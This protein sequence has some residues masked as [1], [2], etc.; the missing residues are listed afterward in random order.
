M[1]LCRFQLR[2]LAAKDARVPSSAED[3]ARPRAG[4]VEGEV[5]FEIR[6]DLWDGRERTGRRWP[7]DQVK[8]L[9][10]V[11]PSKI[12]CIGRNYHEHIKEFSNPVPKQ[13]LLFLKPPSS[14]IASEEAIVIPRISDYVG[15]EGELA[16]IIGRRCFHLRPDDDV[17]PYILGYTPLND[18][19]ARDLQKIDT[20]WGRAKGFDTFCPL[21]PVLETEHPSAD[22]RVETVVNGVKKQSERIAEMIFSIDVIINWISQVMTLEPGDVIA[23]GTPAGVGQ[24]VAGDTVE[25]SVS[26]IGTLRNTVVD[27]PGGSSGA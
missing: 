23:T 12:L 27:P 11:S 16:V 1:K 3:P 7:G 8:F 4:L 14:I 15:Y 21:G 5:V 13:P 9:A 10:P 20:Q 19:T 24:L 2:E 6:G 18:V 17:R 22:T 26:G 25:V